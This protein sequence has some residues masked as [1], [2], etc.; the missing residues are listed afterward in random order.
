M[1]SYKKIRKVIITSNSN[2]DIYQ[3]VIL[4]N[5]VLK[6]GYKFVGQN[7]FDYD[8]K[9]I[10]DDELEIL[11]NKIYKILIATDLVSK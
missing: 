5:S 6:S 3:N 2:Y 1:Y 7:I 4:W 8:K 10:T 11:F 9:K